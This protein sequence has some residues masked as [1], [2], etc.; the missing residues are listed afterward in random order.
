M[1]S[2]L[3]VH[4]KASNYG[5]WLWNFVITLYIINDIDKPL[6]INCDN[7]V[8]K[9]YVKN[10]HRSSKSKHIDIKFLTVKEGVQSSQIII[11]YIIID[12]ILANS[13]TKDLSPKEFH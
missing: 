6:K 13:F 2:E 5:I 9:L 12:S 11:K 1:E 7:K 10:N 8:I 4:Y 3:I